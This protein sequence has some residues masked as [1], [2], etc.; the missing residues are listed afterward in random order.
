MTFTENHWQMLRE[1][2]LPDGYY[3]AQIRHGWLEV[4]RRTQ[5]GTFVLVTTVN[6]METPHE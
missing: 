3:M 4:Y 6:L 1:L 2:R 5:Y